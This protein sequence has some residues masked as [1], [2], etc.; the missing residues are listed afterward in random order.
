M[1]NKINRSRM[2][3]VSMLLIGLAVVFTFGIGTVAA[4]QSQI[5]VNDSSGDDTWNGEAAV[6]DGLTLFGPK[7]TIQSGVSTVLNGGTV[8]I[9]DGVYS[10]TGNVNISIS[11]K[12]VNIKGQ[13]QNGTIINASGTGSTRMFTVSNG[14]SVT[15]S[16][17]TFANGNHTSNGGAIYLVGSTTVRSYLTVNNC[18]FINNKAS[19][20][21]AISNVRSTL[22]VNGC[23]FIGNTAGSGGAIN[24]ETGTQAMYYVYN[25]TF[26]GN[27][28][29]NYGGAIEQWGG[30]SSTITGN[31]FIGNTALYGG[32]L[33]KYG[34]TSEVHFNSFFGN[35]A[36]GGGSDLCHAGGPAINAQ[37]NWFGSND[38]PA[39]K[40]YQ[41]V[42]YTPWL[43]L[44]VTADPTNV[45]GGGTST[46]T[47]DLLHDSNGVYHDPALGHVPDGLPVTFA[48][49]ALGTVNPLSSTIVNG[50]ATT[51]F[52]AGSTS[53]TS[54]PT[55]TVDSATVP[56]NVNVIVVFPTS[57]AVSP[58]SGYYGDTV[59]LTATLTDTVNNMPVS[60][61]MVDFTVNGVYVGSDETDASGIA[62]IPYTIGLT[63]GSYQI[64]AEF[65]GDSGYTT[66]SG[67]NDLVVNLIP[68]SLA[69]NPLSG[70]YNDAVNLIATLTDTHNNVP[71][72]GKQVN[73]SVNGVSAGSAVT[74]ALGV[75]TL[76]YDITQGAG[77]YSILA[78]FIEDTVYA[79]S[80]GTDSLSVSSILTSIVVAPITS[81]YGDTV[82]LTA[83]LT[84]L[85][86][87]I[88]LSGKTVN[89][90]V[91][92]VYAGSDE[93]DASG[94]ATIPY[95][96][97]LTTGTYQILAEFLGDTAYTDINDI[98][99]LIVNHIPTSLIISPLSGSN[100][101]AVNLIATLTDIHNNVALAGQ[102][103]NFL[104]NGVSVG[105]DETDASGVATLQ[106]VLN[107]GTYMVQFLG[108][109]IYSGS[110]GT[111]VPN[112]I[113]PTQTV[114]NAV[115][116][117]K[118]STVNLIATLKDTSSA[119]L[120]GKTVNFSVNGSS[121]GSA[122]TNASG[123]ATIPYAVTLNAG[124][125]TI[126]AQ[127]TGDILN[128]ASSGSNDLTVPDT[129][130]P[131]VT[132]NPVGG[133]SNTNK[134]VTLTTTDPD[135]T[136]T[137][138]YTRDGSDPKTSA[139][140]FLYSGPIT[141]S[142]TTT[143]KFAA[144][145]PA[146][147][148]SPVYTQTYT[149]DKIAPKVTSTSPKAGATGVSRTST[150][151][152][153][154]NKNIKASINWSKVYVKNLRTGRLVS[155]SKWISGNTLYIKT[156]SRRYAYYWY[157]VYIPAGAVKDSAGNNG[158]GYRF[159][160]K[161]GRK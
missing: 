72:A 123:V 76:Q 28:A 2:L 59:D 151:A 42:A 96:I 48:G 115:N 49:D 160:F 147:H 98:N 57:L 6:W 60:G 61:K 66:S 24:I 132:V 137:T 95:T 41:S 124:I 109:N 33:H 93:T 69:V 75:A 13:S 3:T 79:G 43:V 142:T 146:G 73:F 118:G 122:V 99:D 63:N 4:D 78:E 36:T 110:T 106:Y 108:D 107:A 1:E 7:K 103:V 90:T 105:S 119:P 9:A 128:A 136:A 38:N 144:V 101:D 45:N 58:I 15:I 62:T 127:F 65:A 64:L 120:S 138:Y 46:I 143:L 131:T 56:V 47:A 12:N 139:T 54:Q 102:Q 116:G 44:T 67:T 130:A 125:Y 77:V 83:T 89:F 84:D 85:H 92:G 51:T 30:T 87:S 40:M 100:G 113:M 94:V 18:T 5:Y 17:L 53:G 97:A 88:P 135:S 145:D 155:I 156:N 55:A 37:Y 34:G 25:S 117:L 104:V 152:I 157:Q 91:N 140:R 82:D 20:G 52:T 50:Q 158:A 16:N 32:A 148:W 86:N 27:S 149:I 134:I 31:T 14:A 10:G 39:A 74:D 121:A 8:N 80:T 26:I 129:I 159:N 35:T 111:T 21:G 29:T 161:T 23:T 19:G 68:T 22:T 71:L 114:V 150:I 11:A 141:I 133:L 112:V 126:L 81:Y 153:R 154:F 70:Y